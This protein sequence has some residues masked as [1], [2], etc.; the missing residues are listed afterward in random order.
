MDNRTESG[1]RREQRY[2]SKEEQCRRQKELQEYLKNMDPKVREKLFP[3]F[4][5]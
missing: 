4:L 2:Y 3:G 1:D 5:I